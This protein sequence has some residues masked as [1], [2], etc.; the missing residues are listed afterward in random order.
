[1]RRVS[2]QVFKRFFNNNTKKKTSNCWILMFHCHLKLARFIVSAPFRVCTGKTVHSLMPQ[3]NNLDMK[4]NKWNKKKT[5][6]VSLGCISF[7]EILKNCLFR[8]AALCSRSDVFYARLFLLA[9]IDRGNPWWASWRASIQRRPQK[10]FNHLIL[11]YQQSSKATLRTQ[12]AGER[13][14]RLLVKSST[15]C[16]CLKID[17]IQIW[18]LQNLSGGHISFPQ[19]TIFINVLL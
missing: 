12:K 18:S 10:K 5:A 8:N 6:Q 17:F 19:C 9:C 2:V 3:I 16:K 11:F 4:R 1:M 15:L 7:T 13:P 14:E